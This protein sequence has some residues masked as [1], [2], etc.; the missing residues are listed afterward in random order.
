MQGCCSGH[1]HNKDTSEMKDCGCT[2]KKEC[3]CPEGAC[4]C[5][6]CK[7]PSSEEGKSCH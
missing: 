3:K 7:S 2:E 5:E 4:T 1:D 6:T